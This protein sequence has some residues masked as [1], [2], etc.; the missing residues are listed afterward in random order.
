MIYDGWRRVEEPTKEVLG[1][2]N[3]IIKNVWV[4]IFKSDKVVS[5]STRVIDCA[6]SE[7]FL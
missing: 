5:T 3:N 2:M 7:S 6:R 4:D 1:L